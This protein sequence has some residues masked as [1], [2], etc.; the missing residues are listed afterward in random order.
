MV[1]LVS[2]HVG[3]MNVEDSQL[4]NEY[5][6]SKKHID[7]YIRQEIEA[8]VDVMHKLEQ[9]IE[10]IEQWLQGNYYESK[11]AR[12][13]QLTQLDKKQLVMSVFKQTVY[14]QTP[15]LLTSVS[16]QLA[17]RLHMNNK[18]E[19]IITSAE[20]LAVI[21]NTDAYDITKESKYASM[22]VKSRI[23]VSEKLVRYVKQSC[24]LPPMLC[25][26]KTIKDNYQSGYLTHDDSVILRNNHHDDPI[27]LDVLNTQNSTAL[28]VDIEFVQSC[29]EEPTHELD[30]V[31]KARAWNQLRKDSIEFYVL[32]SQ[33]SSVND[34][35]VFFN[36]KYDKRGRLYCQGY[37]LSTQGTAYKKAM[38]ELAKEE[39]IEIPKEYSNE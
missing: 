13:K 20:I 3:F 24:Y 31:D 25:Q 29:E 37:H 11:N 18:R 32:I 16:S 27:A 26:P 1:N 6:Y 21:C 28:S 12:L 9:G 23:P 14:C 19:A 30:S 5:S 33:Q 8:N 2:N 38:L 10:L 15:E 35:Q 22:M 4:A 34:Y 39:F 7:T 17:S 36:H